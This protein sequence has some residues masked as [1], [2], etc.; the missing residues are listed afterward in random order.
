MFAVRVTTPYRSYIH[1]ESMTRREARE[2][3]F[4]V[5]ERI[6]D[7]FLPASIEVVE[8]F[9]GMLVRYNQVLV[10]QDERS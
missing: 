4:V 6:R 3:M 5:A 2:E 9:H 1:A 7:I 10:N 8:D